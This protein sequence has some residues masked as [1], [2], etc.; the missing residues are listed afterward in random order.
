MAIKN[1]TQHEITIIKDDG[2]RIGIGPDGTVARV[3][4][5]SVLVG[6]IH[7]FDFFK[8]EYGEVKNLPDPASDENGT[9]YYIVSAMVKNACPDRKDLIS[10]SGLVRDDQGR[11]IGCKGFE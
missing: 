9:I 3:D 7:G 1:L 11:V 5:K 2:T 8:T 4:T 10:P 6:K